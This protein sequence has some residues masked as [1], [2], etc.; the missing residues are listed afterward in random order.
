MFEVFVNDFDSS[1][2]RYMIHIDSIVIMIILVLH[3]VVLRPN[4][5]AKWIRVR[6]S[7]LTFNVLERLLD[8]TRT[9]SKPPFNIHMHVRSHAR[10]VE[11]TKISAKN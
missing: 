6:L 4:G 9:H 5:F 10:D 7:Q 3:G 2:A 1:I 8:G 11:P